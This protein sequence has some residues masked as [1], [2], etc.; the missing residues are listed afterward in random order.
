[1]EHSIA[2]RHAVRPAARFV[3]PSARFRER[4]LGLGSAGAFRA[5]SSRATVLRRADLGPLAREPPLECSLHHR[6]HP[7]PTGDRPAAPGRRHALGAIG[8]SRNGSP[9][10]RR[11]GAVARLRAAT[12][13]SAGGVVVRFEGRGPQLVVGMRRRDHDGVTWTLPKGTPMAGE[14]REE[15]AVR[16]VGE[17]T[18][19][20]VR[21]TGPLDSISYTF[22]QRG[23]R[24]HK[25]VHYFLMEPIGGDLSRHD[26]EF[27]QVRWIGFDEAP[28]LLTFETE[29][30]LVARAGATIATAPLPA[31]TEAT[32]SDAR[33]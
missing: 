5:A 32:T 24:I 21:I 31:S 1:M 19:L 16:E 2:A 20:E 27:E 29:R 33:A 28:G 3:R 22:V 18:G 13:T 4:R 15:T 17:E 30:A 10:K 25:T 23:T 14:S 7:V 6:P 9:L 8:A 12:A 26:R 11:T